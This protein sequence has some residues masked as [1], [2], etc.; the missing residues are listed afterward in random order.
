[1]SA[2]NTKTLVEQISKKLQKTSVLLIDDEDEIKDLMVNYLTKCRI[3]ENKVVRAS[4]GKEALSKVQ[5]QDF[6]LIII[7]VIMPKMN[8]L[9]FIRELKMRP[10]YQGIPILIISGAIESENVQTAI[11]LGINNII[12]KPFT[13]NMFLEKIA[14][15]LDIQMLS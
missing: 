15:T 4:D 7:D 10:K 11:S 5:N 3:S 14:R 13:F 2:I 8:G 6:G 12:V 9:Q 1:M